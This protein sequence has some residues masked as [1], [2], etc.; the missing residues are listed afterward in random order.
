MQNM[1]S[2]NLSWIVSFVSILPLVALAVAAE[3]PAWED[4]PLP[5]WKPAVSADVVKLEGG[6][7][8][9]WKPLPFEFVAGKSVR[10]IDF[11]KGD[12]AN[13]GQMREQAWKHHP[14]DANATGNA[15]AAEGAQTYVFK[16]GVTYHGALVGNESG[17]Q[18]QPIRLTSDPAWG[19]G[20]AIIAGSYAISGGWSKV[21]PDD[22]K[23]TGFPEESMGKLWSVKVDGDFVP[24]ALWAVKSNGERERLPIARWPNWKAEHEYNIFTQWFRVEKVDKGFPETPIY[25]PKVLNDPDPNAFKGATVWMDHANDS[26]EF[27]IIGPFPSKAAGYDPKTGRLK[28][29]ITHP[30]RHPNPRAPFFLENMAKFLDEAGEWYFSREAD[31]SRTLYIR[32]PSDADPNGAAI[33]LAQHPILLDLT[34]EHLDVSGLTFTG[35]NA[36]DLNDAPRAGNWER[37]DNYTQMAAIRLN[38]NS[39]HVHL[40][41]LEIRDNAGSGIVHL[42]TEPKTVLRDIEIADSEFTNLDN[43]A[44][45]L[46]FKSA[47]IRS[48]LGSVTD[49][50]I[51]RNRLHEIGLRASSDQ[52]GRGIDVNGLEVGE[53][54]GN[55][56]DRTGG[57]GINVVGGRM[58]SE[59]PLVRIQVD[60]NQVRD[61][62][63][64]K[65]DFGG[66]EF[67]G[68]GPA[69]VYDNISINP[70]GFVAHR[71]VYHKNQA[72]YFDHGAKG[73]LFNNIG[74]SDLR[75][76]AYRGILGDYFF[77]EIRNR[78]NEAFHNTALNFRSAST[79]SSRFGSQQHYLGNLFINCRSGSSHWTL[80]KA[81]EIAFA[82]N[83]YAGTFVNVY[84]RW[85][86]E[87]FVN[88]ED[89]RQFVASFANVINKQFGW[90]SDDMPIVDPATHDFRLRDDSA[91]IDRGVKVFVPWSLYGTV[92]EWHFRLHP[93]DPNTILAYD[94]YPQKF[95]LGHDQFRRGGGVPENEL[96]GDGFT[97]EQYIPGVLED[98]VPGAVTFDG[99]HSFAL[100]N[101]KLIADFTVE[102][103]D[104]KVPVAG[105]DRKTVE[106]TVNNF[107]IESV[108]RVEP[109]QTA[110]RIVGKFNAEAGYALGIDEQGRPA[111]RL[112]TGGRDAVHTGAAPVNDGRWHHLIAEV[113]RAAGTI[114]LYLDGAVS[115]GSIEG[116]VPAADASLA[117]DADFIVGQGLVGAI[118]F[119]RV[120][121][122]T[123]ADAQTSIEQLMAWQFNGPA[124]HDFVDRPP[125]GG[126]RDIGAIEHPTVSGQ[127]PIHYTPRASAVVQMPE[128]KAQPV[129]E[130][131]KGPDRTVKTLDWGAVSVPN[132]AKIGETID[133]QVV[134]GTE[135]IEKPQ[136]LCIDIHAMEG[137]KRSPG[138]GRPKP[139]AITPGATKPYNVTWQVRPREGMDRFAVIVYASPDGA[140]S[141]KTLAT[142]VTVA[143]VADGAGAAKAPASK[144][145]APEEKPSE[146]AK[147]RQADAP[148]LGEAATRDLGWATVS[149]P[150]SVKVGDK[151]EL[152]I[153]LKPGAIAKAT[154][155]RID[156]HWYEGRDR[157][158]GGPR[159]RS[160]P[161]T[162]DQTDPVSI[163]LTVPEKPGIT[164]VQYV[165]Y[166]SP[167][168]SWSDKTHSGEV[169]VKVKP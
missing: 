156:T 18:D 164:A 144:A 165:L 105:K 152:R 83:L 74:W 68:I 107:L 106:M 77:H 72:Y 168:G 70:V 169:G 114:A 27:S 118:D 20:P 141:H 51:L 4:R 163:S 89:Y 138:F 78:W 120:S 56:V 92:G 136:Q 43:Q 15:K 29:A 66:I 84:D 38:N 53:I 88:P 135:T 48:P 23:K 52:G 62:L 10:Y 101:E 150:V 32:L 63:L 41:H 146:P 39:Q 125:T 19:Q 24:W 148:A 71:N 35:G 79:H 166:V 132:Q 33:E 133:I 9:Q 85:K 34:G 116:G 17:T 50:R 6:A 155:L 64:Q 96:T 45:D 3:K 154:K 26:G 151:V 124:Q 104:Q 111:M 130:F 91:A 31:N 67:W 81:P 137:G 87:T 69:Y 49:I 80:D 126:V 121:R 160:T 37:P 12:D 134:F 157:K 11:D 128:P 140:W 82:N 119:L 59:V 98:W 90:A 100:S 5:A 153:Q 30:A 143:I 7:E 158:T 58:G 127:K 75:P 113:D 57:Q 21:T 8:I 2:V 122:G 25:A 97:A 14:W 16:R 73:Y 55:V 99:K 93:K 40:H 22:A 112:R 159:S 44:I 28:I 131:R 162:P 149:Y 139:I 110:G 1:R 142:E 95:D 54:A 60:R 94:V 108:F 161:I 167:S 36:R 102:R 129:E 13:S 46:E 123:L 117:N 47:P 61:T 76:D 86:G 42:I 115:T 145:D 147:P 109:G 65:Q 103:K